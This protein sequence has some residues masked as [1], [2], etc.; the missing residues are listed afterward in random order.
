MYDMQSESQLSYDQILTKKDPQETQTVDATV[1][2]SD[3]S[4]NQT[5]SENAQSDEND[6]SSGDTTTTA[7]VDSGN[8][9]SLEKLNDF[10]YLI[11]HYY[12]VDKSTTIN[13][14]QLVVQNLL[15]KDCTN[16]ENN[17]RCA[18]DFNL[19]HPWL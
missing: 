9:V 10:D 4:E 14:S 7:A 11:Q 15:N 17:R 18:A 13:S 6:V 3:S 5:D 1:K 16:S 2:N 12:T 19:S 8:A